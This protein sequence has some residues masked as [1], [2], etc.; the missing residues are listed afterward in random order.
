MPAFA[1]SALTAFAGC[2]SRR[3]IVPP[4]NHLEFERPQ[5]DAHLHLYSRELSKRTRKR[6]KWRFAAR[7]RDEALRQLEF[8]GVGTAF[9]LSGAYLYGSPLAQ[10]ANSDSEEFSLVQAENDFV[11]QAGRNSSGRLI[12]FVSV[13]PL[14]PYALDELSRCYK[15]GAAGLKLHFWNS[16]INV[17]RDSHLRQLERVVRIAT[18]YERPLIVHACHGDL[19]PPPSEADMRKV[20]EQLV[21]PFP[22]LRVCFAHAGGFGGFG[23]SAAAHF[24]AL[25][26]AVAKNKSLAERVWIDLSTVFIKRNRGPLVAPRGEAL[27]KLQELLSKW[28][29]ERVVWGSD[30]EPR[31]L[32][33]TFQNWPLGEDAWHKLASNSADPF[34]GS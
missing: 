4:P 12:P 9:A 21:Q 22:K 25:T 1:G 6:S 5:L 15:A 7:D 23:P 2:G 17:R 13:N 30:N 19:N 3:S 24:S 32:E 16:D 10:L 27:Q 28:D 18:S 26:K 31:S 33:T 8:D 34:T 29:L 14:S 11:L 20:L